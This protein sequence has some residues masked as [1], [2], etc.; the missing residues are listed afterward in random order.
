MPVRVIITKGTAADCKFAVQLIDGIEADFLFADKG[1][2][3]NDI[4]NY[5]ESNGMQVVIPPKSNRINQR[6]YDEYL[7]KLRHLVENAFLKLKRWRG[8]ATRY[9]KSTS[10]FI[11]TVTACCIFQW[12]SILV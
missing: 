12:L 8:V 2:D 6:L 9:S 7:Y 10:A 3:T 5:A 11:G 4:I 1:Y